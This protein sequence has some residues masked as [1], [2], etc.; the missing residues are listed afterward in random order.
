MLAFL[1][2]VFLEVG[3]TAAV[4]VAARRFLQINECFYR[5]ESGE[6]AF[7][8]Q[9]DCQ[10]ELMQVLRFDADGCGSIFLSPVKPPTYL[11]LKIV[12]FRRHRPIRQSRGA[13]AVLSECE[14]EDPRCFYRDQFSWALWPRWAPCPRRKHRPCQRKQI[15]SRFFLSMLCNLGILFPHYCIVL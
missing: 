6:V 9:I 5:H 7:G 2:F 13:S 4:M 1:T 8:V 3:E 15:S 11:R 12:Y 10:P 14:N